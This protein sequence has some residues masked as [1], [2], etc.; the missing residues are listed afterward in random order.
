[1]ENTEGFNEHP[2]RKREK[3]VSISGEPASIAQ[4]IGQ[5][6]GTSRASGTASENAE[7]Q[8]MISKGSNLIKKVTRTRYL[9]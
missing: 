8:Q 9:Q 2:G 3:R 5:T 7:T 6:D 1:M 4:V